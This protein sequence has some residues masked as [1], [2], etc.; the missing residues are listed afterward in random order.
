MV[1]NQHNVV[2]SKMNGP[3]VGEPRCHCLTFLVQSESG[4]ATGCEYSKLERFVTSCVL[5]NPVA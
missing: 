4:T 3:P 2:H 5:Q 1:D